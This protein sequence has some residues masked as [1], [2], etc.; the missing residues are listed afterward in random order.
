MKN[1]LQYN[2]ATK[3]LVGHLLPQQQYGPLSPKARQSLLK[4]YVLV[5]FFFT[6]GDMQQ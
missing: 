4:I 2:S 6:W 5:G 1:L 3:Y